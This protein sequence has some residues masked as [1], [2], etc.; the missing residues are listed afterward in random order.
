ML[1]T[2]KFT[3]SGTAY[4]CEA[5]SIND[6]LY[7]KI[8][9]LHS[10]NTGVKNSDEIWINC[11]VEDDNLKHLI[12][13]LKISLEM[14]QAIIIEF[15]MHYTALESLQYSSDDDEPDKYIHLKGKLLS[16]GNYYI[17][18]INQLRALTDKESSVA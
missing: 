13:S 12:S 3:F 17:N 1:S 2:A 10:F 11:K 18:G 14:K 9:V 15:S 4:L 5:N 8:N 7:V 16:I 6:E